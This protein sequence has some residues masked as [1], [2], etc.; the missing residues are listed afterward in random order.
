VGGGNRNLLIT[1]LFG[2][3]KFIMCATFI[4]GFSERW[5]R[6]PTFWI[7]ALLMACCFI[8]VTVVNKT[9]PAPKNNQVTSAGIATVAMIFLTNSIYQFSWGPLPWPYTAEVRSSPYPVPSL[10]KAVITREKRAY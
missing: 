4:F 7:S 6:K 2:A 10:H 9:T 8:I 3:E 5:G 1:G